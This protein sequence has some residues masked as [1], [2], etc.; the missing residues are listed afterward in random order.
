MG[1]WFE[2][3]ALGLGTEHRETYYKQL[4]AET[5]YSPKLIVLNTRGVQQ[6]PS[7]RRAGG[8]ESAEE[9]EGKPYS[10]GERG[11]GGGMRPAADKRETLRRHS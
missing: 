9:A 4:G 3:E 10:R 2:S 11:G 6:S 5:L 7:E 1:P 8:G